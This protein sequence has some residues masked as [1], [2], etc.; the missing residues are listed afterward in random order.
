MS[1][2]LAGCQLAPHLPEGDILIKRDEWGT[3]HIYAN[4][5]YRLF[6]GYG[7]AIAQDRLFQL[8]M[9]RRTTQGR[10]AE[11]L[12]RE[13]L[14]FDQAIRRQ[15]SPQA[16]AQQ[17]AALA[18]HDLQI[19]QGYADGIN[20]HLGEVEQQ[21]GTLLPKPF[22]VH[23]FTPERW[24][25]FDVAM[26]YVGSMINRFGD[27]NTELDNHNL[28][29]G[30]IEKHGLEP[31]QAL[32]ELLLTSDDPQAPTT[33][34]R[35][36]WDPLRRSAAV[37]FRAGDKALG[38][39][40]PVRAVQGVD[41]SVG[42]GFSNIIVLGAQKSQDARAIMVN[43][44]QFGFFQPAYTYSVGLHGAGYDAVGNS[45]SGYPLI[46]FGHNRQISWGS[47]WGAGDNVD[48]Y[49]LQLNPQNPNQY[50]FQGRYRDFEQRVE[51]ILV[52]GEEAEQLTVYR[53]VQGAVFEHLPDQGVA[54][55]RRRGWEGQELA[56]LM[57]WNKVA[58]AG[59]HGQWLA[60]VERSAINVNWY[61]ADQQGNIGYAL[62][63][64]YPVRLQGHDNRLPMPGDGNYEWQGFLPFASN[65]QVFN[66]ASGY[67]ANWNNKPAEG[68]P[69]PDQWWYAWGAADRNEVLDGRLQQARFTPEQAWSLMMEAA[70]EDPN[71]RYFVP[72]LLALSERSP[73]EFA[74]VR[75]ALA[76]W[77]YQDLDSN[78]D[79]FYDQPATAIFRLWLGQMLSLTLADQLPPAQAGWFTDSGYSAPGASS[80]GSHNISVGTKV[81]YRA[82]RAK[83]QGEALPF[84]LFKGRDVDELMLQALRLSVAQ[85]KREQGPQVAAWRQGVSTLRFAHKNFLG[86][87]QALES[88]EHA[89]APSMNLGTE[90]NMVVLDGRNVTGFELAAPGQSGF[91]AADGSPGKHYDDQIPLLREQ[92]KRRIWLSE[93]EVERRTVE[94]L[95]L[96][97]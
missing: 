82:I 72:R 59:D 79:G 7:Y 62:G 26:V 2:G 64:R 43:G 91:I 29:A 23:G 12:G 90:N 65:P 61:Y 28:L 20:R 83:E 14:A 30:L 52:N 80:P 38:Q 71:A 37:V 69:G 6:Y 54:Y 35:G 75:Q 77:D 22:T 3:P 58:K 18:P 44:P 39:P 42:R 70:F 48:V 36:E 88:E 46:Q 9:S 63:G 68:F 4:S 8:E 5:P 1:M 19:L 97:L 89:L 49:Q 94:R 66:P 15:Y 27:Y 33:I 16:I 47:T 85:L 24:T 56:T 67:I 92:R 53:S 84:D 60:Q 21:P 34:A 87:P 81:L 10:V 96:Q 74:A 13:Y 73:A 51:R 76:A 55:A 41:P 32:F 45:P 11:V 25:A 57:A 95:W 40:L 93:E 86:V 17:L 31:G 50:W 78:R